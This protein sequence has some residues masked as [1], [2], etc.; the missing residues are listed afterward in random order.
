MSEQTMKL[1]LEAIASLEPSEDFDFEAVATMM[2]VIAKVE[3]AKDFDGMMTA[4]EEA[5]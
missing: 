3:L 5:I 1:A 2:H 4:I